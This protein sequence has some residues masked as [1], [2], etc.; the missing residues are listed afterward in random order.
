VRGKSEPVT[1]E[2]G[3]GAGDGKV[4]INVVQGKRL[5]HS[6]QHN[7]A[8]SAKRASL[9]KRIANKVPGLRPDEIEQRLE[10]I[11]IDRVRSEEKSHRR[12]Q[13]DLL[14]AVAE[15]AGAELFHDAD[16]AYATIAV[17]NASG[18]GTHFETHP[19]AHKSFRFWLAALFH[20]KHGKVAGAQALQDALNTLSG[21]ARIERSRREIAIRV[22]RHKKR[23]Y[24]DLG[25]GDGRIVEITAD[26]WRIVDNSPIRFVRRK[27]MLPLPVPQRGAKLKPLRRLLNLQSRRNWLL[28]VGWLLNAVRPEGPFLVLVVN[29][30]QG[31]AKTTLCRMLR[32]LIDP[33]AADLRSVPR[34][35]SD[36][37]LAARNSWVIAYD[38]L[39]SISSSL[40][41]S[42]ARL[43]TGAGFG[44]R[45]LYTD[46]EERLYNVCRPVVLNG[47]E[48]LVTRPDLLERSIVLHLPTIPD[49][50]RRTEADVWSS[51]DR[52]HPFVLG[53]CSMLFRHALPTS[54]ASSLADF[55]G[56]LMQFGG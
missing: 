19:I 31:S 49:D 26:G 8:D 23:V 35:E 1:V 55:R 17:P 15:D 30:E 2:A 41:D 20:K 51:F 28:T 39:S 45:E 53:A 11:Q 24:Y 47:I 3:Q 46:D 10:Q 29:G 25:D 40:S 32:R 9:A 7:V 5:L 16:T 6:E 43:S 12:S 18:E 38:N 44:K 50:R 13:A 52:Q 56:W 33:N 48:D 4:N 34:D 14:V 27:G 36:I 42:L 37:V 22:A 54:R 21:K